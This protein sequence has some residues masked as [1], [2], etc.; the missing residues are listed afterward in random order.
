M[1]NQKITGVNHDNLA[2]VEA[3]L[4]ERGYKSEEPWNNLIRYR[5]LDSIYIH[6]NGYYSIH[7]LSGLDILNYVNGYYS[8]PLLSGVDILN[9][10]Q[11]TAEQFLEL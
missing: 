11:I 8:I 5:D 1:K 4:Q 7:L 6:D 2:A 9:Y 10:H 3:K